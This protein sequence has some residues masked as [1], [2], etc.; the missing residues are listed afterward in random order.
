MKKINLISLAIVV[1]SFAVAAYFYP[2]LPDQ[3]ASHWHARGEVDGYMGK[4]WGLFLLPIVSAVM[5]LIFFV[6]PK[7]DPLK[8][9][10]EAF[11][12]YYDG[13]VLLMVLF[14]TYI[15]ALTLSWNFGAR[16]DMTQMLVPAIGV[17]FYFIGV[18]LKHVKR[19]WFMGIRTPWTLSSD[20][21]WKKTHDLGARLFKISGL[22]A[23][24]GILFPDYAIWLL[25]VLVMFSSIY[26]VV[27]S[28]LEYKRTK[29]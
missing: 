10:I 22:I 20:V 28:Y 16:F 9:N 15:F 4:F 24:L 29:A 7:I 2:Q 19:N 27:Y 1:A 12:K 6:I 17:M 21:V 11:R 14:L 18:V 8:K 5:L 13:F 3:I 23:L 25:L 26:T